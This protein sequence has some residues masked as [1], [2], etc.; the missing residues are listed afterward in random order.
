MNQRMKLRQYLLGM[1]SEVQ[2]NE[3]EEHYFANDD[4]FEN[5]LTAE[6]EL[7][8]AYVSG[9]LSRRERKRFKEYLLPNPKW[10]QKV[11]NIRALKHVVN[12]ERIIVSSE[13]ISLI[14]RLIDWGKDFVDSLFEQKMVIGLSYAAILVLIILSS[15]WIGNQF[16]NFQGK[17]VSLESE[18][19]E[20]VQQGKELRQQ[21]EQQTDVAN[22]FAEKFEQEKQQRLKLEQLLDKMKPEPTPMVAFSL[23]P[24]ILRDTESQRRLVIPHDV[25]RVKFDLFVE[26]DEIYNNYLAVLKTVEG[27]EVYSQT[28]LIAQK[29]EWGQMLN[30]NLPV[31]A[32]KTDDYILTLSGITAA[33]EFE[34]LHRYFFSLNRK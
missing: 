19:N 7:V 9:E 16:Q 11:A 14:E 5:M 28:G 22:E 12:E 21:V 18:Q 15:V 26:T 10:Q 33:G 24:G 29:K 31:M 8:E 17:I 23:E 30:L 34:I 20:L 1:V 2:Q 3:I 25:Q 13:K 4:Y 6:D 32:L 27:Y